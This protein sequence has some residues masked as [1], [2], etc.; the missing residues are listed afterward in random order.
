MKNLMKKAAWCSVLFCFAVVAAGGAAEARDKKKEEVPQEKT[1][2]AQ[3][4]SKLPEGQHIIKKVRI[5]WESLPNAVFYEL[6]ILNGDDIANS[7]ILLRK[8]NIA[9][10]GIELDMRFSPHRDHLYWRVRALG[11]DMQPLGEYTEAKPLV[12]QEKNPRDVKTTTSYSSMKYMKAYPVYSWIP[13]TGA[14]GYDLQVFKDEDFNRET[15]DTLLKYARVNDGKKFDYYDDASYTQPGRYWWRVRAVTREGRALSEWSERAYFTVRRGAP[16]AALGDSIT[17]GGGAVSAPPSDLKYDW[18]TY[19]G[20]DIRNL[21]FSG[22]TVEA[23]NARF[24]RDVL[25][26]KPKVLVILGGINNIRCGDKAEQ[27]ILGLE[28]L[29]YKCIIHR[30]KPVFVTIAPI[31]PAKMNLVSGIVTASSWKNEQLKI[32][33]W[34]LQQPYHLD[35][36]KPLNDNRGWLRDELATD[37]LHPDIEGKKIIGMAIGNYL[38]EVFDL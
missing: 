10:T 5:S 18:E 3:H 31:H 35:I 38:Q 14:A 24:E 1:V 17:H 33:E 22:N 27:V 4:D 6:I 9:A 11:A 29:K 12:E 13:V 25:A 36:T 23:M 19:A 32:N 20:R 37:G 26:D 16:V 8:T 21:G 7:R 15:P 34:I 28:A 2:A 30:I